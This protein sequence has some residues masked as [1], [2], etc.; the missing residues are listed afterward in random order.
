MGASAVSP[1][2]RFQPFR[3]P[4]AHRFVAALLVE[5]K[6]R[7]RGRNRS[8]RCKPDGCPQVV[9]VLRIRQGPWPVQAITRV[10][11]ALG[12]ESLRSPLT[13]RDSVL[14][15]CGMPPGNVALLC[16]ASYQ[17]E[18]QAHKVRLANGVLRDQPCRFRSVCS[19]NI[20]CGP[21]ILC[22]QLGQAR[23]SSWLMSTSSRRNLSLIMAKV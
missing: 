20:F 9:Y 4:L 18:R 8:E 3:P 1:P 10:V 21:A 6:L 11:H 22:D 5:R 14:E 12:S 13:Q 15:K 17:L 19:G 16:T 2:A 7:P 23:K